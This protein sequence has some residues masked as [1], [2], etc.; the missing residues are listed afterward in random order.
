MAQTYSV[1]T[2]ELPDDVRIRLQSLGMTSG[3]QIQ[4][5]NRKRGGSVIFKIRGTRLAVG[6]RI[7]ENITIQENGG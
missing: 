6:R 3:T 1:G 7:A 2:I 5:L 4:V